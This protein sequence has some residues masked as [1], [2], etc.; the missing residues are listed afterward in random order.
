[1]PPRASHLSRCSH[2]TA[3]RQHMHLAKKKIKFNSHTLFILYRRAGVCVGPEGKFTQNVESN[4]PLAVV[5]TIDTCFEWNLTDAQ[6][7]HKLVFASFNTVFSFTKNN[8]VQYC[9]AVWCWATRIYMLHIAIGRECGL[10]LD[11]IRRHGTLFCVVYVLC[12]T[13]LCACVWTDKI[14]FILRFE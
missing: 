2:N 8:G 5:F 1:M 13:A 6:C 14:S 4:F 10:S 3:Q 7:S 12:A 11:D 9:L